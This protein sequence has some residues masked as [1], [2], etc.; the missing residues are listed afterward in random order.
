MITEE[1]SRDAQRNILSGWG[2]LS[3]G[4][5][6]TIQA[7]IQT[8][9]SVMTIR[10]CPHGDF[11]TQVVR[12]EWAIEQDVSSQLLSVTPE[13]ACFQLTEEGRQK[14]EGFTDYRKL[15]DLS[16]WNNAP[17]DRKP[18]IVFVGRG[19]VF[20]LL[21]PEKYP[22]NFVAI[23]NYPSFE[24]TASIMAK[25]GRTVSRFDPENT[26]YY[27]RAPHGNNP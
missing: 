3:L 10:T 14:L 23:P 5:V 17:E 1:I 18:P 6:S 24:Q 21:V 25:Q 22:A 8:G 16:I 2:R 20:K 7:S 11:W 15:F 27:G 12:L 9:H 26:H 19:I 4:D 13:A